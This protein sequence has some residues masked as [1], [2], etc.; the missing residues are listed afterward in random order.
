MVR[1]ILLIR[2]ALKLGMTVAAADRARAG[3]Y[4][5]AIDPP[6]V[7]VGGIV[8]VCW[9]APVAG[10]LDWIAMAKVGADLDDFLPWYQYVNGVI[11]GCTNF[12]APQV[13]GFYEFRYF[14]RNKLELAGVSQPITVRCIGDEHCHDPDLCT[15]DK[16]QSG[17][18]HH[19]SFDADDIVL[20]FTPAL[21]PRRGSL[22]VSWMIPEE[23]NSLFDWIS[24]AEVG[25]PDN[26]YDS[27]Q[28]TDGSVSG[29]R[30]FAAPANPG[31]YEARYYVQNGD[32]VVGRSEPFEVCDPVADH[33]CPCFTNSD[34]NDSKGCS[35]DACASGVCVNEH[36]TY[37]QYSIRA[38][39]AQASPGIPMTACWD[40]TT[41][42]PPNPNDSIDFFYD[43]ITI[44]NY[45]NGERSGCWTL[46]APKHTGPA[47][48]RYRLGDGR[49]C[50]TA[51]ADPIDLCPS[52]N[53]AVLENASDFLDCLQG[54][55]A[56]APMDCGNFETNCDGR[57]DLCDVALFQR[58]F[59]TGGP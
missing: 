53:I 57:I 41:D 3:D 54:P 52:C 33:E 13:A 11:N 32:C 35:V 44:F 42:D 28:Y 58:Y 45:T 56:P 48:F 30:V 9:S 25:F 21:V 38:C 27:Y 26:D 1:P 4:V 36:P 43:G 24:V 49:S 40:V 19:F 14:L 31:L 2:I 15:A 37:G 18:C 12:T 29:F 7:D 22:Y 46:P 16:C 51:I 17:L 20:T 10:P 59:S 23:R 55:S 39:P 34:C 8:T 47:V 50:A 5:L 6:A